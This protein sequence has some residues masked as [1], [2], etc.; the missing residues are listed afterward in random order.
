MGLIYLDACLVIYLAERHPQ[1]SGRLRQAMDRDQDA[2]F[3]I[4]PL[5]KMECM[6]GV[7]MRGD[8]VMQR[9]YDGVFGSFVALTMPEPVFLQAAALRAQFGLKTPDALHLACAQHHRCDALWTNDDRLAK[10][11]HGLARKVPR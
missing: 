2:R 3:V 5:V 1:W 6:V 11:S 7:F 8:I 4:S 9:A 10:A